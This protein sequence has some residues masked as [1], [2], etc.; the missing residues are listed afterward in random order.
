ME[1]QDKL[2]KIQSLLKDWRN[3]RNL[4]T[5]K[6]NANLEANLLEEVVEY[7][8]AKDDYEK[9]DALCDITIFSL[10]ALEED[11]D[12]SID[13][14]LTF[15]IP[16]TNI[17]NITIEV[18]DFIKDEDGI[19]VLTPFQEKQAIVRIIKRT[20]KMIEDLGYSTYE[21]LL[22]TIKEISSRKGEYD[23]SIKKFVKYQG[24][25][26][27]FEANEYVRKLDSN[28]EIIRE[29]KDYWY[30]GIKENFYYGTDSRAV[31]K[32]I[33]QGQIV[34]WYRADYNKCK[35]LNHK[36]GIEQ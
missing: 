11:I 2:K 31:N 8:R 10:N 15:E 36:K 6:Q 26:D 19:R 20:Y 14:I 4:D 13:N 21:C 23:E 28:F 12:L 17:R 24:A 1:Q 22:E 33:V 35:I 16:Y 25:Y 9:V 34:K 5:K 29:D 7:L 27:D 30:Y 18:A 32:N 3:E